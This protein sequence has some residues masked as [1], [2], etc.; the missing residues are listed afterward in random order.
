MNDDTAPD[1]LLRVRCFGCGTSLKEL[2]ACPTCG[3]RYC[4]WCQKAV[5]HENEK[6]DDIKLPEGY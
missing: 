1:T 6:C 2:T 5:V 4:A 3:R